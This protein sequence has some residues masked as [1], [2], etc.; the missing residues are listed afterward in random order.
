MQTKRLHY[1]HLLR[2]IAICAVVMIHVA[3]P[4]INNYGGATQEFIV[5]SIFDSIA[6]M[7]VP[8]FLMI[9]GALMLDENRTFDL[10]KSL[11]RIVFL[12]LVWSLF[13]AFTTIV[14]RP[15]INKET[16]D[17]MSF[18]YSVVSGHYH[19]WYMYAL[20]GLYLL[21]PILRCFVT[22]SNKNIVLYLIFLLMVFQFTT[23]IMQLLLN[24]TNNEQLITLY[25]YL[26]E[27]IGINLGEGVVLY[28]LSGW[29]IANFEFSKKKSITVY[30]IGI[31]SV[32][33]IILLMQVFSTEYGIIYANKNIFIFIYSLA[34]FLL[35][36]RT[37]K[38]NAVVER[39]VF[40]LSKLTFGVYALHVAVLSM[41][42]AIFSREIVCFLP[43]WL[44]TV[45]VSFVL[46]FVISKLPF[47]KKII[48]A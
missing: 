18:L 16:V 8:L 7:G 42:F 30:L 2:V 3:T 35:V 4:F 20:A 10:K 6:R 44:V 22:K 23:P 26:N 41:A 46:S 15:L 31:L 29:Y 37:Y 48:K 43:V 19:L 11:L 33:T 13:Y 1:L 34:V 27:Q 39:I 12:F 38:P 14:V 28:Y 36:K 40:S 21:T 45:V 47:V 32:L 9:S 24:K 25:Q 5:A 17:V